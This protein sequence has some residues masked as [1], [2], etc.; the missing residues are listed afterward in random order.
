MSTA[1]SS[2]IFI[3]KYVVNIKFSTAYLLALIQI[4]TKRKSQLQNMQ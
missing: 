4:L 1:I 2:A 3:K